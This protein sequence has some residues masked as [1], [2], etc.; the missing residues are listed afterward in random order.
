MVL[1]TMEMQHCHLHNQWYSTTG[2]AHS[3]KRGSRNWSWLPDD[4][5]ETNSV[6]ILDQKQLLY[7]VGANKKRNK[8]E[9][10]NLQTIVVITQVLIT[11]M[12][13]STYFWPAGLT[14]RGWLRRRGRFSREKNSTPRIRPKPPGG[15]L[16]PVRK[17]VQ[18]ASNLYCDITPACTAPDW[19]AMFPS[20]LI[21]M[22]SR[23]VADNF[24]P[25]AVCQ[26]LQVE[27]NK[28]DW[29]QIWSVWWDDRSFAEFHVFHMSG[30]SPVPIFVH[31][32]PRQIEG[33]QWRLSTL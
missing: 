31:F 16:A 11:K 1:K 20:V 9:R 28:G 29:H 10:Q 23:G 6:I 13:L 33:I 18:K 22:Q 32:L 5:G 12:W 25:R 19:I 7:L 8:S 15:L 2:S 17:S 24:Q 30:A 4:P 14:H 27:Q 26:N 21:C 3:S